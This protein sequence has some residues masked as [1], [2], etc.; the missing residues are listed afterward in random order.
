MSKIYE[1][2]IAKRMEETTRNKNI[3]I[4][5]QFGF[6]QKKS[7]TLQLAKIV[8]KAKINFNTN[9]VTS[10]TTLDLEKAYDTV[11]HDALIYKF[12]KYEYPLYITKTIQSFLKD[13]TLPVKY[14]N[15]TS[16][17]RTIQAG[18]P[19]GAVLSP[20]LFNHYINDIPKNKN[21]TLALY[22]DDTAIMATSS[23]EAMAVTYTQRQLD[24]IV[25]FFHKW[26]LQLNA[27]KTQAII[28]T[29]RRKIENKPPLTINGT[30]IQEET[31]LKYLG[32]VLDKTLT[33]TKHINETRK[34]T[35]IARRAINPYIQVTTP[36]NEK[37]KRQ[38][39]R[40]YIQSILM[41]A[42][43]VWSSTSKT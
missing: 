17:S 2:I 22:A 11:W 8:D 31:E 16:T 15:T 43:P 3:I 32:V 25:K 5:E 13:R 28:F 6:V 19:Q 14:N 20:A 21:T 35:I 4:D 37:L 12:H 41:Y 40:A 33:F 30:Q 42:A 23:K 38:L 9:R 7:T 10:F 24:E 26:K 27:D 34:K 36:L 18:V 1:I 29:K 39:Y